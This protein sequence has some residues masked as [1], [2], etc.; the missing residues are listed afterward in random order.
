M[1]AEKKERVASSI[2]PHSH[3]S[4]PLFLITGWGRLVAPGCFPGSVAQPLMVG[5]E[6]AELGVEEEAL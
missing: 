6:S 4:F 2:F 3:R 5:T 1:E